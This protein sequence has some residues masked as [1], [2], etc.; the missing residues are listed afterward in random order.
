LLLF[1][2]A[3]VYKRF[4]LAKKNYE[5]LKK[6]ITL[7]QNRFKPKHN[8]MKSN[9]TFIL[10]FLFGFGITTFA[11]NTPNANANETY[12]PNVRGSLLFGVGVNM[13]NNAPLDFQIN[14]WRSKSVNIYYLYNIPLGESRFSF[15][16]GIGLGME[17]YQFRE[18]TILT[19]A[20]G[21]DLPGYDGTGRV[22]IMDFAQNLHGSGTY[23]KNRLAANYIDVPLEFRFASNKANPKGGLNIALGGKIGVLFDAKTKV[24][25]ENQFNE[26]VIVKEKRPWDLNLLRYSAHTRIGFGGFNL[27]FEYQLSPLFD[28]DNNG[29]L[30]RP[31]RDAP[32]ENFVA[33]FNSFPAINNFR[34]GIMLDLF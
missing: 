29:P 11:Q 23:Q 17:K 2:I 13:L 15:N 32:A 26:T 22:L 9:L 30:H 6:I 12:Q 24:K 33:P 7:F 34:A 16:P 8:F 21:E 5:P 20:Q 1:G 18:N 28:N 31:L 25:Y 19:Y 27:Y 10:L 3:N 4:L 14:P